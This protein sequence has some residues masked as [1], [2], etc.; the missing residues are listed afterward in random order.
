[1]L[2]SGTNTRGTIQAVA[3]FEASM[4]LL[5]LTG[6]PVLGPIGFVIGR[7]V[8]RLATAATSAVPR[9]IF[10]GGCRGMAPGCLTGFVIV[11]L[12]GLLILGERDLALLT[13]FSPFEAAGIGT[14]VPETLWEGRG[15][16]VVAVVEVL[17]AG[18]LDVV[19]DP[20]GVLQVGIGSLEA[21]LPGV[22]RG[23]VTGSWDK[24]LP[25]AVAPPPGIFLM[26]TGSLDFQATSVPVPRTLRV[27]GGAVIPL[28]PTVVVLV[29][30]SAAGAARE[31][32]PVVVVVTVISVLVI[33]SCVK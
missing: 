32:L 25:V 26:G 17:R 6:A 13:C 20:P 15:H 3:G 7:W 4:V 22:F 27:G 29:N 33:L 1:M 10:A 24:A 19:G 12:A 28:T 11:S 23:G 16:L 9:M 21:S 18:S 2:G 8:W 5:P 31:C 14:L 30:S